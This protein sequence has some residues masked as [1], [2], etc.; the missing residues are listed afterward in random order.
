LKKRRRPILDWYSKRK[1]QID[2]DRSY[3]EGAAE[4]DTDDNNDMSK[5]RSSKKKYKDDS[6][7]EMDDEE[8]DDTKEVEEQNDVL[9]NDVNQH[10]ANSDGLDWNNGAFEKP[11]LW[12]KKLY[13][14]DFCEWQGKKNWRSSANCMDNPQRRSLVASIATL[15]QMF[16][17]YS[18]NPGKEDW[19]QQEWVLLQLT[20]ID[21]YGQK[22]P[23]KHRSKTAVNA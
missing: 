6:D 12:D 5:K 20:D 21:G 15:T 2:V 23:E 7:F 19:P 14:M 3:S 22:N 1:K 16:A 13:N 11:E 10:R 9:N 17:R 8:D 4:D 18:Q